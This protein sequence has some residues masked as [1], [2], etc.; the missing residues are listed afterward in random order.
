MNEFEDYDQGDIIQLLVNTAW[1][2]AGELAIVKEVHNCETMTVIYEN[3]D[4]PCI[5]F[6]ANFRKVPIDLLEMKL[7]VSCKN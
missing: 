4:D 3:Q 7:V 5:G 2:R 1:H 6:I